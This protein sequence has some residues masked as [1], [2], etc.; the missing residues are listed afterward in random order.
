M[1]D[2]FNNTK[3]LA[4]AIIRKAREANPIRYKVHSNLIFFGLPATLITSPILLSWHGVTTISV[5]TSTFCILCF[6]AGVVEF[7]FSMIKLMGI[8]DCTDEE[9][10]IMI[11]T[12]AD[13][14][15]FYKL[16]SNIIIISGTTL[17]T[18]LYGLGYISI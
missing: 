10:E 18:I 11:K 5:A 3:E 14:L 9:Q 13:S 16:I 6:I 1:N 12:C 15:T 7:L 2:D 8:F 17:I 4:R